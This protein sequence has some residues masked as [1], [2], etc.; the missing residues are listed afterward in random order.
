MKII[1]SNLKEIEDN[2]YELKI[3]K[4]HSL[5]IDYLKKRGVKNYFINE[6]NLKKNKLIIEKIN[7]EDKKYYVYYNDQLKELKNP[8]AAAWA[9]HFSQKFNGER[10]EFENCIVVPGTE[11]DHNLL[12]EYLHYLS[13]LTEIELDHN[14]LIYDKSGFNFTVYNEKDEVIDNKLSNTFFTEGIT[15]YITCKIDNC[16]PEVYLLNTIV[17][18]LLSINNNDL[19][20]IY[21]SKDYH[22]ILNYADNFKKITGKNFNL[23]FDNQKYGYST[24]TENIYEIIKTI[25]LYHINSINNFENLENIQKEMVNV[26][27]K[28]EDKIKLYFDSDFDYDYLFSYLSEIVEEKNKPNNFINK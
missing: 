18:E 5:V 27:Y 9:T 10:W 14:K 2:N 11:S 28:Y 3:E 8:E 23:L 15:E 19:I 25:M 12:H 6:L 26:L 4:I 1:D 22:D 17:V 24:P 13:Y 16:L 21:F 7:Y 20:N